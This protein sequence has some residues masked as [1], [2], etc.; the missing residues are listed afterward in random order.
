M[1]TNLKLKAAEIKGRLSA[2][3]EINDRVGAY[4]EAKCADEAIALITQLVEIIEHQ[5]EK[6][7]PTPKKFCGQCGQSFL[8]MIPGSRCRTPHCEAGKY[9]DSLNNG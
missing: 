7:S 5:N 3:A 8:S 6:K 9:W 4:T 1:D 2:Y